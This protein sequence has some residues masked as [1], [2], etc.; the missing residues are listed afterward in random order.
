MIRR[1]PRSTRTDTLFPYTTRFR[2]PIRDSFCVYIDPNPVET[3]N[4]DGHNY[5]RS[6]NPYTLNSYAAFGEAYYN[7]NPDLKLTAGLRYTRDNKVLPPVPSQLLM[8]PN[9]VGGGVTGTV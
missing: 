1:P 7:I 2:S 6:S 8:A 3:I 5:F 9:L 4:G